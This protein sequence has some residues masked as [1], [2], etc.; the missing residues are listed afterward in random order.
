MNWFVVFGIVGITAV[1]IAVLRQD[2]YKK[3]SGGDGG[4]SWFGDSDGG[5]GGG[6]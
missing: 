5:D 3:G 6:D 4:G 2:P 1:A